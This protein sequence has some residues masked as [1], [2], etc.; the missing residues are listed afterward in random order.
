[1]VEV[2]LLDV[3][4]RPS[5]NER[6]STVA[7]SI[8]HQ[9]NDICRRAKSVA[10][11]ALD[12]DDWSTRCDRLPGAMQHGKLMPLGVD[13]EMRKPTSTRLNES[14]VRV[15]TPSSVLNPSSEPKYTHTMTHRGVVRIVYIRIQADPMVRCV[16]LR[17]TQDPRHVPSA[18]FSRS[19]LPVRLN[20]R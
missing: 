2:E 7:V 18:R 16:P 20:E 6:R 19:A 4:E 3:D 8:Q 9:L 5:A 10:R 11:L 1:M 13:L 12:E 14:S 15:W 17:R